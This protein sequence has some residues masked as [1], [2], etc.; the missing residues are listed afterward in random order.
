M[1]TLGGQKAG[2]EGASRKGIVGLGVEAGGR[3]AFQSIFL[4]FKFCT[5]CLYIYLQDKNGKGNAP[6]VILMSTK[7]KSQ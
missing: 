1:P 2:T 4:P 3:L 5:K 6:P 7:I